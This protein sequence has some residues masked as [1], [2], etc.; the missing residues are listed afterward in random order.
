VPTL[1]FDRDPSPV[2]KQ[3]ANDLREQI[4]HGDLRVGDKLAAQPELAKQY[5]VAPNTLRSAL[6]ELRREGLVRT[7][8]TRGTVV[9]AVPGDPEPSVKEIYE[10]LH[11]LVERL[12]RIEDRLRDLESRRRSS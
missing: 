7:E 1:D 9:V 12:D 8:S 3:I 4:R 2:F 6:A 11:R 5:G 10:S